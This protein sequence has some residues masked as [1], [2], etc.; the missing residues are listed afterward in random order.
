MKVIKHINI[1]EVIL[2]LDE[3]LNLDQ[4]YTLQEI[5]EYLKC[6]EI[7]KIKY[8]GCGYDDTYE[9]QY[10]IKYMEL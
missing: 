8:L 3:K 4:W 9:Y 2:H 1:K 10:K 6:S 7:I 5:K